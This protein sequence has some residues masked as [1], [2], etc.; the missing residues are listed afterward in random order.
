MC[1]YVCVCVCVSM[2][3]CVHGSVHVSGIV[4]SL[5]T[6]IHVYTYMCV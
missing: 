6:C 4:Y 1:V 5:Y 3:G 2:D